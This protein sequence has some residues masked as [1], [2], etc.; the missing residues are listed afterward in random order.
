[1]APTLGAIKTS[2]WRIRVRPHALAVVVT[3]WLAEQSGRPHPMIYMLFGNLS[4]SLWHFNTFLDTSTPKCYPK[5]QQQSKVDWS[6][7]SSPWRVVLSYREQTWARGLT[8]LF[9]PAAVALLESRT[10]TSYT[11][12]LDYGQYTLGCAKDVGCSSG[13][14]KGTWA[15]PC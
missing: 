14:P 2:G 8:S 11:L 12:A 5:K 7:A 6:I 10:H 4:A 15:T 1:M 3:M 9:T 13:I